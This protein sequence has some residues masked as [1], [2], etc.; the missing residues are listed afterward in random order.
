MVWWAASPNHEYQKSLLFTSSI[1]GWFLCQVARPQRKWFYLLFQ[2][3]P[4]EIT[5]SYCHIEVFLVLIVVENFFRV[6]IFSPLNCS[7]INRT[8]V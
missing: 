8:N 1:D 6:V 3:S 4:L 7:S 5:Y 2:S